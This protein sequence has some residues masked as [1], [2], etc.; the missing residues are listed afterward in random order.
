[1]EITLKINK[2]TKAGRAFLAML[3]VFVK[4]S[5]GVEVVSSDSQVSEPESPYDPEFV[6]MVKESAASK[7]RYEV[8]DVN[9]LWESL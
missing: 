8:K 9:D 5:K 1:M 4:D 3:D 7:E 2:R 6:K